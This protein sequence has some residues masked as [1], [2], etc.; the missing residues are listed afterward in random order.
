M[1]FPTLP[2]PSPCWLAAQTTGNFSDIFFGHSAW[3]I[4][5]STT[6]IW[7]DYALQF[8]L[9][10]AV[11]KEMSFSSYPGALGEE[12]RG[13]GLGVPYHRCLPGALPP[14]QGT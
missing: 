10:G 3:F 14:P 11:G 6:R 13:G 4:Y 9:P 8:N 12:G 5:Q 1:C 2:P 7:K